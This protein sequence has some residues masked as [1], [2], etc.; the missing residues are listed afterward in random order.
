[1]LPALPTGRT[2]AVGGLLR[3]SQTSNAAV[4]WPSMRSGFTELTRA[5][6]PSS[7][8][9]RRERRRAS[10]KLPSIW[11]ISA[12]WA[13]TWTALPSAILPA[14][15][16]TKHFMPA[17]AEYAEA[18]AAVLPVEAQTLARLPAATALERATVM[19]RSLKEAVGFIPSNFKKRRAPAL[20]ERVGASIRGV[21]PSP[22]V[23]IAPS[24]ISGSHRRYLLITPCPISCV[25]TPKVKPCLSRETFDRHE[26]LA[27]RPGGAFPGIRSSRRAKRGVGSGDHSASKVSCQGSPF[28]GRGV[29]TSTPV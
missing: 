12:P 27:N 26:R 11:T 23:A 17:L 13:R 19:P 15:T 10:S 1:M 24:G 16:T 8:A 3:A 29:A 25:R 14:G 6:S 21:S 28:Q 7:S 4:F 2:R 18:E 20:S 5:T 9:A 22:K